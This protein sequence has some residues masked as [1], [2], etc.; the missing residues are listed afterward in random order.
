MLYTINH[1]QKDKT[2]KV[3]GYQWFRT[4]RGGD[5]RKGGIITLIKLNI[6]AY[7]SSS[8]TDGPE[9]HTIAVKTLGRDI[10]LVNY[11]CPNIVN[12]KLHN[13]LVSDSS[14]II[15]RNFNSYS[16]SWD[17]TTSM[18]KEGGLKHGRTITTSHSL[19][20]RM[21]HQL[22]TLHVGTP[23][24]YQTSHY[25]TQLICAPNYWLRVKPLQFYGWFYKILGIF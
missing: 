19:I 11:Y 6:N 13:I 4:D 21:T 14:F 16:Q 2:F 12:L 5:R 9:H 17:M 24:V 22:S 10:R 3:T 15:M 8:S 1:L 25:V 23:S 7:M 20:N 18:H